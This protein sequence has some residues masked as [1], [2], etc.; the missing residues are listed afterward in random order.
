MKINLSKY[1]GFC[2]GVDRAY[3]LIVNAVSDAEVKKPIYVMGSLVHNADVVKSLA[4][5]GVRQIKVDRNLFKNIKAM[6]DE[7]G[8]LVITAHGMGPAIY[9]FCAKEKIDLIDSTCPRVVKVQRLAQTFSRKMNKIILVGDKDHKETKGIFEWSGN[10]AKVVEKISD[11]RRLRLRS[12]KKITVLFQTT[13][14]LDLAEVFGAVLQNFC[15]NANILNTICSTTSDRQNEIKRMAKKNEAVVV[16]GS[17]ESANS[18]RL[19]EIAKSANDR[20]YFIERAEDL[21][22]EWFE[23][24]MA[25]GVTAGASTPKWVIAEVVE[26]LEKI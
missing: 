23:K 7:I 11:L 20:S 8:T 2:E 12:A 6:K 16:I 5:L 15:P 1:A 3:A 17:P 9:K 26:K 24:C 19:A 10:T 22:K 25:I 14:N 18:T 13:Q 21:Q 4:D